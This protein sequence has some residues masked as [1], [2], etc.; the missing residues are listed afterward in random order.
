MPSSIGRPG[1]SPFQNGILPGWPGA[2]ETSTRSCGD[3]FDPP[4]RRAEQERFAG[5]RL[6]HHLLVQFADARHVLFRAGQEHAV[7]PAVG[8]GAGVG[9][10]HALGALPGRERRRSRDPTSRA[11]AVRRIRQTGSGPTACPARRRTPVGSGRRTARRHGPARTARPRTSDPSRPWRRS[12]G[13]GRRADCADSAT[14]PPSRGASRAVTA[15]HASRS[16]RNFG[17]MMPALVSSMRCPARPMRCRPLATEGGASICT[18]RSMAPM[19][20]PS[21]SDEVATSPRSRPAFSRSSISV[22]CA[23]ASEP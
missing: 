1:P 7:E 14:V 18:T 2:G 3:L 10:R 22:R 5:P 21:S 20:M 19:S 13:R 9:D 23:R 12:A 4:R 8:D 15:A 11:A 16:P 6:E 17:K